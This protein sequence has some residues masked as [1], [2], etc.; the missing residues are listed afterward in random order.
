[1]K[2]ISNLTNDLLDEINKVYQEYEETFSFDNEIERTRRVMNQRLVNISHL[3]KTGNKSKI[4]EK[5]DV[6]LAHKAQ[7]QEEASRSKI[8]KKS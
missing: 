8:L 2:E 6:L 5:K 1:M 3:P 7:L 4:A